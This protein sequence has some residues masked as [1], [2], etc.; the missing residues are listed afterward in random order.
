MASSPEYTGRLEKRDRRLMRDPKDDKM[1]VD[2]EPGPVVIEEGA[3]EEQDEA[4]S[5]PEDDVVEKED[6]PSQDQHSKSRKR[7]HD[8]EEEKPPKRLRINQVA[9]RRSWMKSTSNLCQMVG[10]KS[11][12]CGIRKMIREL[13]ENYIDCDCLESRYCGVNVNCSMSFLRAKCLTPIGR[14]QG[15]GTAA[16]AFE[17]DRTKTFRKLIDAM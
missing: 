9:L 16:E 14:T 13:D 10:D 8:E 12:Y 2:D 1:E 5:D 3:L 11:V 4:E 7:E 15:V 6:E 17:S